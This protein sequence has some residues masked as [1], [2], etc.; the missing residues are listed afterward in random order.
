MSAHQS[1]RFL[2]YCLQFITALRREGIGGERQ[3]IERRGEREELRVGVERDK[4]G[5]APQPRDVPEPVGDRLAEHLEGAADE[6][7]PP[8]LLPTRTSSFMG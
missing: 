6:L 7:P 1:G 4:I 2:C 8:L 5:L 3:R